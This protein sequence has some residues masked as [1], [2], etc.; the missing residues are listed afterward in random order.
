MKDIITQVTAK[1]IEEILNLF[2]NGSINN[3]EKLLKDAHS[4][5]ATAAKELIVAGISKVDEALI[6]AK[7]ERR[8]DHIRIQQKNVP[9]T[10]TTGLGDLTYHRTY[11]E[12]DGEFAYLTD[13]L[14]GVEPYERVSKELCASLVQAAADKSYGAVVKDAGVDLSRQTVNNKVLSL[15]EVTADPVPAEETPTELH[16]F[17]DEDHVHMKNGKCAIVPLITITEGIDTSSK[18]HQT[19]NPVHFQ[20]YGISKQAFLD[21]I[22]AFICEKYDITKIKTFYVHADGSA[23]VNALSDVLPDIIRALDKF[24]LKK[25]LVS[26]SGI[27]NAAAYIPT[28]KRAIQNDNKNGFIDI[29][30]RIADKQEKTDKAAIKKLNEFTTYILNNWQAV[31]NRMTLEICGSCTEALVSHVLSARLS[32]NPLAWSER[33][34]QKMSMLRVYTK[35][36][37]MVSVED[38]RRKQTEAEKKKEKNHLYRNGFDKYKQLADKQMKQ[39][40][41]QRYDWSIFDHDEYRYGKITGTTMLLKAYGRVNECG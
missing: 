11:F 27:P 34:L 6:A 21:N 16:I 32:R 3:I 35:N 25:R 30:K 2:E 1:M 28:I 7:A 12:L 37:G 31:V 38:I 39:I 40:M 15:G 10:L 14:I 4:I 26:L 20:G 8:N 29:C 9:R 22:A 5:T 36:G 19:I 23:A 33:G 24:H 41:S 17:G 18:R 13:A